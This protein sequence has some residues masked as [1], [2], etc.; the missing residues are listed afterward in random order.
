MDN[1]SEVSRAASVR[2]RKIGD[3]TVVILQHNA[4][5]LVLNEIGGRILDLL[6]PPATLDFL[7]EKLL[8]EYDIDS[9]VLRADIA[10]Y[11]SSL[12]EEGV[13]EIQ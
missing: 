9:G 13:V 1:S 5:M 2:Y 6:D 4:E 3:E 7:V 10:E 8:G 11:V 12:K